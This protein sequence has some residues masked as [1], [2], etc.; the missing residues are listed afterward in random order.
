MKDQKY[1]TLLKEKFALGFFLLFMLPTLFVSIAS[2]LNRSLQTDTG[3]K[4]EVTSLV[5][6]FSGMYGITRDELNKKIPTH[7]RLFFKYNSTEYN[8]ALKKNPCN[9]EISSTIPC[10]ISINSGGLGFDVINLDNK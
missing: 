8:R 1:V 5:P 9:A 6:E 4:I 10:F 3:N 2:Y 7:Y